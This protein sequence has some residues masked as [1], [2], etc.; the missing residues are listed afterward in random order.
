MQVDAEVLAERIGS[1]VHGRQRAHQ[2]SMALPPNVVRL[3]T[4]LTLLL[5]DASVFAVGF[6]A[7]RHA[8]RAASLPSL[9]ALIVT[10]IGVAAYVAAYVASFHHLVHISR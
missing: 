6:S 3:L 8:V 7:Q 10:G 4:L 5:A 1:A 2:D 9:L